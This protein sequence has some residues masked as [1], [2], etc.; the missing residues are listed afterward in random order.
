M[1]K[2]FGVFPLGT[3]YL[4]GEKVILRV[5]EDRYL[6]LMQD[7]KESQFGFVS[8]LIEQGSEVGG[9]DKRFSHGVHLQVANIFEADIGLVVEA[10]ATVRVKI[11]KWLDE[12]PYPVGEIVFL[13]EGE[14]TQN[15]IHEAASAISLLAQ[16]I[17]TL[18]VMIDEL[19]PG[20]SKDAVGL[21]TLTTIAAGR[22]WASGVSYDEVNRAFWV[23]AS[24]V[25]CG[26][27][28]R[29]ELLLPETIL[30]RIAI[31]RNTIEHVSELIT[32]QQRN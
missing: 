27:L 3:A 21:S 8:V 15:H 4:P 7:L 17:R 25:P 32:F 14:P 6:T 12:D 13:P 26:S 16:R 5:F 9:G 28:D 1:S 31:L 11:V 19:H 23:I 30:K 22:W 18:H 24:L 2:T 10:H 29:Y 20:I